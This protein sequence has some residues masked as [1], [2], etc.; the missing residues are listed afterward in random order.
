MPAAEPKAKNAINPQGFVE[1][2]QS[3]RKPKPIPTT[4]PETNSIP[5]FINAPIGRTEDSIM[6]RMVRE[7][8]KQALTEYWVDKTY[9]D[10][11]TV[12]I[13]LH[14]GRTHQIR[15]HLSSAGHPIAGDDKYGDFELNRQLA[16]I[17]LKRMFLHA[18]RL[19]LTH[20]VTKST[21]ELQ[22]ELPPELYK[23]RSS[24][25]E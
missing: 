1:N 18:W 20:P 23:W 2:A 16:R 7:D 5:T 25:I 6:T 11:Q 13:K 17:G 14:T 24:G 4:T 9:P 12:K 15:V 3:T 10:G 21:L 19:R 22:C 8:G